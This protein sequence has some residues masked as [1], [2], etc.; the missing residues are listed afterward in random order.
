MKIISRLLILL[1]FSFVTHAYDRLTGAPFASR[2]EVI[3]QQGMA[4]TSQ[5]L[6]TQVALDILKQGG[7]AVDA[8][9]AANA[10]LGLVEPTGCGIGGDLF[11][12]VWDAETK[13]LHGL[14]ASGR[15]PAALKAEYFTEQGL[16]TIP[17]F[18]PL[19]VSVPGA[20][21]GWFSLHEKF[22]RLPMTRILSPAIEYARKGY[23]VS[24]VVAYYWQMNVDRIGEYEGFADVFMP[25]GKAPTTGQIFKNPS[26]AATYEKIATGG[27]DAFYK[28]D[29]ARVIGAYMKEQGGF[30][31]YEDLAA[32]TSEWVEPVST[33][34]RGY[35]IW[36][37]P[38]NG[39]GIAALQILNILEQYDI[40]G[41]GFG[42]ADYIHTFVEAKKLAFED[43][44]KYY[45]DPSFNDIPVDALIS[46]D[47][48]QKRRALINP[49][50]AAKRYDAGVVEGDT[51]YLTVADK[52]GNMV[53]LIQSNYRGMGSGM[54]PPELGFILQ[55]R[56]EL[57][58]L[59]PNHFNTYEPKK[60]PFHTIIPAMVTR[61]NK[62]WLSF[63]VMGGATQPQMHAQIVVN[64]IDFGMNL[65][66]AG[67][68]PRFIHV[69]S[70]SPTGAL[71]KDGGELSMETGFATEVRRTLY[72]RGHQLSDKL[73]IYG[74]YQ[75][76]L[77]DAD[78][79][80]YFG[81]SESRKD[82]QAAGY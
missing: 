26:L 58:T 61:N 14:N 15:S 52:D 21:D 64:L 38:P 30:L 47:Y 50:K 31:S 42:S 68:A 33:N 49:N 16:T 2:S 76:I 32:H 55:N 67:D 11:A 18:G 24:E 19:P 53:S 10:M 8:A 39:Q 35:D 20:V 60:R 70:S 45:A 4:A 69:G 36:E 27:R 65:Q 48:A 44:A 73:G 46:K 59:A 51:I 63:G 3:A 62:P 80:V 71:M 78:K 25:N 28:G 66:E 29:I 75:A 77:Y 40:E 7:S 37:L 1:T 56:G 72:E 22:G 74:G 13:Q 82:G 23:P 9:I 79:Q 81:A 41:M 12:I 54:T 57:F 5:P 6:A 17:S 43:R 34:Y